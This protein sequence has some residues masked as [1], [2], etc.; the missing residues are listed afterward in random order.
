[1]YYMFTVLHADVKDKTIIAQKMERIC[2]YTVI[3]SLYYMLNNVILLKGRQLKFLKG[4]NN[5]SIK[6]IK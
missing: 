5:K 3:K 6:K 1:M 2:E 4:T